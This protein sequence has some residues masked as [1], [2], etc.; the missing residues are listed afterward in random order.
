M[1]KKKPRQ[2]ATALYNLATKHDVVEEVY[3]SLKFVASL[4][5]D[6]ASFRLFFHTMKVEPREKV[7]ILSSLLGDRVHRTVVEFLGL[8]A[9]RKEH[10]YLRPAASA[11]EKV[12]RVRMNV[13]SV[14]AFTAITLEKK[15]YGEICRKLETSLNKRV[16]MKAEVDPKLI[17]G[18]KLRLGNTFVDGSVTTQLDKMRESLL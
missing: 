1:L 6:N 8:L 2:Y 4:Y 16:E 12:Y 15:E 10:G 13:I 5:E 18:L 7:R 9:E 11:F 17:G 3:G 14:T